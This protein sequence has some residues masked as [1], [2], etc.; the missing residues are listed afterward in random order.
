MIRIH[1]EMFEIVFLIYN[2]N[3]YAYVKQN[4]FQEFH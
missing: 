4:I 1:C 2:D 3:E